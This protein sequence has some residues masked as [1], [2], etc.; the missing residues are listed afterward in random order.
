MKSIQVSDINITGGFWKAKQD[1]VKSSTLQAVY[2]R[3]TDSHR[4][5]AFRC[6]KT[7]EYTPHIYWDSD[8]AKWIEGAAYL[9]EKEPHPEL[10]EIIDN[11]VDLIVKNRDENG[12]YNSHFLVMRPEEKFTHRDD[13]EIY[14]FGHLAEAAIAYRDAT[15][16]DKFLK[17]VCDYADYIAKVFMV[18]K[19]A[20]YVTPGH[21]EPELALVKLYKATGEKRY[22]DLAK[23]FVDNH[24]NNDKDLIEYCNDRFND[25]Y[26]QDEMPLKDRTTAEG[27]CVRAMYLICGAADVAALTGDKELF[28]AAKRVFDN[29]VNKRMY[30]TGGV[31]SAHLGESFT[32]DYHLPGRISYAETCAAI[33]LAIFA[34]HMQGH[35]IDSKYGDAFERAA[36]NGILSGVSLDGK[37]FFYVNALEIDPKFNNVNTST[38]AKE[39]YPLT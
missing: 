14:C 27:H 4:F 19:S 8:V 36:Y 22:L 32:I 7:E 37:A 2:D 39:W 10:E 3:F 16:K 34:G 18:D 23:F 38:L 24:G 15:G 20:P 26:N 13:H 21:P 1:M 33:G 31:G 11:V 12:Y 6:E 35:E 28:D 25:K 29:V 17:A 30:I 9:L 5:D